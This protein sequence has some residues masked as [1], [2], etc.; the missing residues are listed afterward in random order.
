M[1]LLSPAVEGRYGFLCLMR[2]LFSGK[3]IF[4]VRAPA[5]LSLALSHSLT[6]PLVP[7]LPVVALCWFRLFLTLNNILTGFVFT[8]PY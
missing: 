7:S 8:S 3:I 4:G 6:Y 2:I 5:N 1:L